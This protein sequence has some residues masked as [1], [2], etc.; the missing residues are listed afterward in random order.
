MIAALI[1]VLVLLLV[2]AIVFYIARLV[3]VQFGLPPV[4]LQIVGL[5]LL[6]ILVL[7]LLNWLGAVPSRWHWSP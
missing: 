5:I 3:I 1:Q 6:L 4:L 7:A 2:L